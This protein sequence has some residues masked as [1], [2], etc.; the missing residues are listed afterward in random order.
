MWTCFPSTSNWTTGF[1]GWGPSMLPPLIS[2]LP[3]IMKLSSAAFSSFAM[4]T[5][6]RWL[7]FC[8]C[9]A[10]WWCRCCSGDVDDGWFSLCVI[11]A[12]SIDYSE[13]FTHVRIALYN[14]LLH[15]CKSFHM[16]CSILC[17][18]MRS[19]FVYK[20]KVNTLVAQSL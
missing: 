8:L 17:R 19:M 6:T 5:L 16:L 20:T 11:V 12:G 1:L 7:S 2:T 9:V 10:T 13:Y 14:P 18:S 15:L 4:N 3:T